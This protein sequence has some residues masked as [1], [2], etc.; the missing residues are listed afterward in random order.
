MICCECDDKAE[1]AYEQHQG[2]V[3]EVVGYCDD[4]DPHPDQPFDEPFNP[5]QTDT[6]Q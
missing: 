4:H 2:G 5:N 6:D 3:V 1:V